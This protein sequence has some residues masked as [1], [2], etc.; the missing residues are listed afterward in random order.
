MKN[1]IV[2][3]DISNDKQRNKLAK[4]LLEFGIRTQKSLFE[5]MVNEKELQ[6]IKKIINKYSE[7]EDFVTVYEIKKEPQR[8]GDV[9]YIEVDDLVF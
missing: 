4:A 9:K 7:P 3:Y 1:I 2:A 8:I 6:S 5:C